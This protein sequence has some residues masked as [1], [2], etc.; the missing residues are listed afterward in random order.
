MNN[1]ANEVIVPDSNNKLMTMKEYAESEAKEELANA[2]TDLDI[3]YKYQEFCI[4]R[5]NLKQAR[6]HLTNA[7]VVSKHTNDTKFKDLAEN[8]YIYAR[9]T[10]NMLYCVL[11]N[12]FNT[13]NRYIRYKLTEQVCLSHVLHILERSMCEQ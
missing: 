11:Q 12:M 9:D 4:A 10:Y 5:S 2:N 8:D 7:R 6:E 3:I 13:Y 1:E